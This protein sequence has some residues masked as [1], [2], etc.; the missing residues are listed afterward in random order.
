MWSFCSP[1]QVPRGQAPP[2][3][4][5][6][7]GATAALSRRLQASRDTPETPSRSRRASPACVVR[8]PTGLAELVFPGG[9]SGPLPQLCPSVHTRCPPG[10]PRARHPHTWRGTWP[11]LA[12]PS[13]A[14]ARCPGPSRQGVPPRASPSQPGKEARK[15]CRRLSGAS[16][17]IPE[18]QPPPGSPLPLED[19]G[20]A[21]ELYISATLSSSFMG[22][23]CVT[24]GPP[25]KPGSV[26]NWIKTQW[27]LGKNVSPDLCKCASRE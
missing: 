22:A 19:L 16:P 17:Q 5:R 2:A 20:R 9:P 23:A 3:S 24:S 25:E 12:W 1:V 13:V 27:G 4:G 8:P 21:P 6:W 7:C 26:S 10:P 14:S 11:G 18:A 15:G